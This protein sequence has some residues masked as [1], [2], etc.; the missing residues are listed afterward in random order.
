MMQTV[1]EFVMM[2]ILMVVLDRLSKIV[3]FIGDE[4]TKDEIEKKWCQITSFYYA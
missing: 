3:D 2:M 4:F 1:T